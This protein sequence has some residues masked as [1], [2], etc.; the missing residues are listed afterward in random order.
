MLC[1]ICPQVTLQ[2]S[3]LIIGTMEDRISSIYADIPGAVIT[4]EKNISG[5]VYRVPH[6]CR[7]IMD[8]KQEILYNTKQIPDSP[9]TFSKQYPSN[10][11]ARGNHLL[12]GNQN[13]IRSLNNSPVTYNKTTPLM[14][15]NVGFE[16]VKFNSLPLSSQHRVTTPGLETVRNN[17]YNMKYSFDENSSKNWHSNSF[18]HTRTHTVREPY[19]AEIHFPD[20]YQPKKLLAASLENLDV[21]V[22]N[23]RLPTNSNQSKWQAPSS[24]DTSDLSEI[25]SQSNYS[26]SP[27]SSSAG[28]SNHSYSQ[29][30]ALT[31]KQQSHG[32]VENPQFFRSLPRNIKSLPLENAKS[33]V[34]HLPNESLS[35]R[36][37]RMETFMTPIRCHKEQVADSDHVYSIPHKH[38][39]SMELLNPP[40][41]TSANTSSSEYYE[42]MKSSVGVRHKPKHINT[43][44]ACKN[45]GVRKSVSKREP[46]NSSSFTS[47]SSG[48]SSVSTDEGNAKKT[49]F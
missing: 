24:V 5:D 11:N 9:S 49:Y 35:S 39:R 10:R 22:S 47:E 7:R 21:V 43:S 42:P 6:Q 41:N 23:R 12:T 37:Y 33:V 40:I 25:L 2:T 36:G 18:S 15:R 8:S 4:H 16:P 27:Y 30:P 44:R 17:T 26:S 45:R 28:Q 34:N 29:Y 20:N 31:E 13:Y 19:L 1:S 38:S 14:G 48:L 46:S 32:R 3:I